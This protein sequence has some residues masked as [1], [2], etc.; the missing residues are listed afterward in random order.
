MPPDLKVPATYGE[1][2]AK[3][4]RSYG[5]VRVLD[6]GCG[7]TPDL[8]YLTDDSVDVVQ[9]DHD[10]QDL[11]AVADAVAEYDEAEQAVADAQQLPFEDDSFDVVYGGAVFN[12]GTAGPVN[13]EASDVF[14]V[15]AEDGDI[16]RTGASHDEYDGEEFLDSS[17]MRPFVEHFDE[18][19]LDGKCFVMEGYDGGVPAPEQR[20]RAKLEGEE[21]VDTIPDDAVS[22]AA[23]WPFK[24]LVAVD[25]LA[26]S[27][28]E[29]WE[30]IDDLD[31]DYFEESLADDMV[32]WTWMTVVSYPE[33]DAFFLDSYYVDPFAE[34]HAGHHRVRGESG[35]RVA[36][37]LDLEAAEEEWSFD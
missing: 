17:F 22:S 27:I 26:S 34:K 15:L 36:E 23:V 28:G 1:E 20:Y 8:A 24:E 33:K 37:G 13:L 31:E 4:L 25:D 14:R 21:P 10:G 7:R 19:R 2:T 16:V 3:Q 6:L 18:V 12:H 5:D 11:A 35:E 9:V 32:T 30:R 29:Q